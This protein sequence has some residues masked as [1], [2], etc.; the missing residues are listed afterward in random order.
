MLKNLAAYLYLL[1][2]L[3]VISGC[4][5]ELIQP[6]SNINDEEI[7]ADEI[8]QEKAISAKMRVHYIDVGQ[9]DAT[10][11]Q[12]SEKNV[13]FTILIDTGD[14]NATDVVTYLQA[15][16]I[17]DIDIIAITHPHADHIGQLDKI[18]DA[19]NVTE[20]WMNGEIANSQVFAK[21]L[22]AIEK[23]D[24]DYYEPK[25]GDLFDIGPL[26]IEVLHPKSMTANTNNNSL[27]MR[28]QYGDIAFL[29]TGDGEEKAEREMLSSE[30][31]LQAD[32]LHVGHHGSNTSTTEE[33]LKAVDPEIAIYSAG[34]GNS[35]G[36]PDSEVT[37]RINSSEILLYGTDIHGTIIVETDGI[38][39]N[40]KTHEQGTLP[41][42]SSNGS[43]VDINKASEK[44]VQRIK[45]IGPATAFELIK[46][47][48]YHSVDEL[49]KINGIG[50]A[51]LKDI[52][53]QG[54]ACIGG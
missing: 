30:A 5:N 2:V 53:E 25:V 17:R 50:P 26:Q 49:V 29:F 40:V 36:F 43:C 13:D 37:D 21:S 3:F 23:N 1:I 39:F 16:N 4:S 54:I 45:H 19:F 48:P 42:S 24:V 6:V 18:I 28:M 34:A 20:V 22:D 51:R 8:S 14:W 31:N 27:A 44:D 9:A 12:F 32:I 41:R 15:E 38:T 7:D 35:Y 47:R 33:F 10:L 11:L 46:M 52:K